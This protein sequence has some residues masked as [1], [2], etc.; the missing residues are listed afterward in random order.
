[1]TQWDASSIN[2]FMDIS[3]YC[4]A[5]CPQ[6]HRTDNTGLGK[7]DWLPL[8]QWSL[9]QFK[10]VFTPDEL[11]NI[12]RLH[13]C[14]TFGDPMMVKD[15]LKIVKYIT[16]NSNCGMSFDTNGSMRN[17]D[18]WWDLGVTGGNRLTVRFDVDGINQKMHETYRRFTFLDKTLKHMDITSQTNCKVEAQTILFKH[19]EDYKDEIRELCLQ[20]GAVAH[21]FVTSDRFSEG[22]TTSHVD[23][24]GVEF[25]LE[26][27]TGTFET[28]TDKL[29]TFLQDKYP[30][31]PPVVE[32]N[33]TC[34]W[35]KPRNEVIVSYDGQVLPCC[36]H[37]NNYHRKLKSL[38][39]DDMYKEYEENKLKYNVFH[40]PLSEILNS[41]WWTKK[42]PDSINSDNPIRSCA[43]NCTKTGPATNR[44][45]DKF[46]KG[47]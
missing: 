15:I 44:Q 24:K 11:K 8:V 4:N 18:F 47:E 12:K 32:P 2:L 28:H 23:E 21:N 30:A 40:T 26:K 9:K 14:G 3:T 10:S 22:P 34:M 17:E 46:R 43:V 1:M 20:H 16:S 39:V 42:L 36:Y 29:K 45:V 31:P 41:E 6:C 35:A 38:M 25:T 33:I 13:F 19:N 27:A 5:G 37:Q 7:V